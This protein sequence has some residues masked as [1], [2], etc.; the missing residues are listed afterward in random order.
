[1]AVRLNADGIHKS[2]A[3]PVGVVKPEASKK[4]VPDQ[5]PSIS[6]DPE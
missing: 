1:M 6:D 3:Q 2:P 4:T 5:A